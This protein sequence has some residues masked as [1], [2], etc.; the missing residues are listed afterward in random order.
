MKT[1]VTESRD[2]HQDIGETRM[3]EHE[4]RLFK[5]YYRLDHSYHG[6]SSGSL[7]VWTDRGFEQITSFNMFKQFPMKDPRAQMHKGAGN[8][9]DTVDLAKFRK[10]YEKQIRNFTKYLPKKEIEA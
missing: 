5:L 8:R 1:T 4:G 6:Q 7:A 9:F 2:Y 3:I 10:F